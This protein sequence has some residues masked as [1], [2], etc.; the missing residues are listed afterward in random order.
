MVSATPLKK[1]DASEK[2]ANT[3]DKIYA[4]K[5]FYS[6]TCPSCPP[7]KDYVSSLDLPGE[8]FNASTHEGLEEARKYNIMATPT[9]LL[10]DHQRNIVSTA[11][12]TVELQQCLVS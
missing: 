6:D 10:L 4:Y 3:Q 11:H 9:V 7:V 8:F 2:Q 1:T 12:N 5:L